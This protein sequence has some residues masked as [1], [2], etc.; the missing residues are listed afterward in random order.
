L[1]VRLLTHVIS[2]LDEGILAKLGTNIDYAIHRSTQ[3]FVTCSFKIRKKNRKF[4]QII[5]I[6][7]KKT[8]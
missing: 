6:R 1:S 3:E 5:K 7:Q 8:R 4:Y 2:S